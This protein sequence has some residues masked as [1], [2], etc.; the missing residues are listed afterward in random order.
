MNKGKDTCKTLKEI[1][2]RIAEAN[3]IDYSPT[4]CSFKGE[5]L[6]TCPACEQEIRFLE[7]KLAEKKRKGTR[8]KVA[9]VAAGICAVAMPQAVEAQTKTPMLGKVRIMQNKAE[10]I[11]IYDLTTPKIG[12]VVVRGTVRDAETNEPLIGATI[13]LQGTQMG[14]ATD[15][16]GMFAVRVAPDAVLQFS[17]VGFQNKL[18]KVGEL[19]NLQNVNITLTPSNDLLQGEIIVTRVS[20]PDDMY[21]RKSSSKPRSHKAKRR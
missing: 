12:S 19:S 3:G 18:V 7:D 2:R 17:F 6:G 20:R 1:R 15:L 4:E 10:S 9:A 13:L 5:C 21:R 14:M 16:D 11:N 8:A